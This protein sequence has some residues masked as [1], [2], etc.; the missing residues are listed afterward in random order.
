MDITAT[1]Q[2]AIKNQAIWSSFYMVAYGRSLGW[3]VPAEIGH[4][5]TRIVR[6]SDVYCT[7]G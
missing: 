3:P 1:F 2:K 7:V 5:K 4:L 6:Y